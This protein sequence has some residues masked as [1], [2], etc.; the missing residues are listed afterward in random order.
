MWQLAIDVCRQTVAGTWSA[1]I[2]NVLNE[3]IT[4]LS[5]SSFSASHTLPSGYCVTLTHHWRTSTYS[6][7]LCFWSTDWAHSMLVCHL[8]LQSESSR[9]CTN[10]Q[11]KSRWLACFLLF[12]CSS[13]LSTGCVWGSL[14]LSAY[15]SRTILSSV[16]RFVLCFLDVKKRSQA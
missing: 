6:G 11:R 15:S 1:V 2:A 5:N 14:L 12:P 8:V 7:W 4:A 9:L 16:W 10:H 3:L 13:L